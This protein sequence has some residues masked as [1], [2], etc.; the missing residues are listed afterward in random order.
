MK[1]L[2][3]EKGNKVS[4][5]TAPYVPCN[6][7]DKAAPVVTSKVGSQFWSSAKKEFRARDSNYKRKFRKLQR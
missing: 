2:L 4:R 5:V 7:G 3:C 6:G 1:D